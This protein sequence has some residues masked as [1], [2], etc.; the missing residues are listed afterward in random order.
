M[1]SLE[2]ICRTALLAAVLLGF[3]VGLAAAY[4]LGLARSNIRPE[5]KWRAI[6]MGP[7]SFFLP[8]YYTEMGNRYRKRFLLLM[9]C[10][11]LLVAMV[12]LI[13]LSCGMHQRN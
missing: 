11:L 9:S 6:L 8:L 5:M 4:Y 2:E 3:P 13:A 1:I 12:F 7:L 10:F